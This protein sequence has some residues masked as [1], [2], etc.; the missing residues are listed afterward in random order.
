MITGPDGCTT[1][2]TT[3][4]SVLERPVVSFNTTATSGCM[5]LAVDF[6]NTSLHYDSCRWFFG[7][8][9][10]STADHPSHIYSY[11][12]VFDVTLQ[13]WNS[14][15]CSSSQTLHQLVR[16]SSTRASFNASH[17]MGCPPLDVDFIS[18]TQG[19]NLSYFW[20]FGD[21]STS[22]LPQPVHT[23]VSSGNF[24]VRLIVSDPY[25]CS[26][27]L[28]RTDYIQ[29]MNPSASY[30][31]PPT[32]VGCAPLTTRFTDA[33][34]GAVSWLWDFGDGT[35]STL[36]NPEH[37]YTLPGNYTVS[38]T[39]VSAGGGCVQH[40]A[41]FSSFDVRGGYAGFTHQVSDC[42]PYE[43]Q[44]NDT[45]LNA[46]S[47]LWNFGDGSISTDQ[48]PDHTFGVGGYHSV[49]LTITT[50]DG[51]SY[52]TMQNNGVYF[53]PF[54]ANFYGTTQDTAYP[55][56]V[57]FHANSL[58][59]TGWLWD[60]G[61]GTTSTLRDPLHV[62]NSPNANP[63]TLTIIN[64]PCSLTYIQPV[65]D[66]GD[67]DTTPVN[68]GAPGTPVVQYGCAP[69]R[70]SFTQDYQVAG[71]R[72]FTW[73]FGDGATSFEQFPAH[74]YR[75]PGV[76]SVFLE[77]IDSIG[78]P[79]HVFLDSIVRV[80]G[81]G[82][83][84]V[85]VQSTNCMQGLVTFTDTSRNAVSW[86]W[87][88]GDG[89]SS[90]QQHPV[91]LFADGASNH[92]VTQT[93]MDTAGCSSSISTSLFMSSQEPILVTE[94]D[95]CGHDTVEFFTSMRNY[96]SYVWHF[97]DGDSSNI[98]N[99]THVYLQEGVFTPSLTT[100]DA[101]GCTQTWYAPSITVNLPQAAFSSTGTRQG[102]DRLT[103]S[104]INLSV[105]ADAYEWDFGDGTTSTSPQPSH[106]YVSPGSYTVTL[107][108]YSDNCISRV[109]ETDYFRV[110]TAHAAFTGSCTS[111]CLPMQVQYHD[112]SSNAVS[113]NWTFSNG[114]TSTAANPAIS[115]S[116]YVY[117]PVRLVITDSNGCRDT[118]TAAPFAPHRADF[119]AD[120]RKGCAPHS[121]QFR[122]RSEIASNFLWD[123]GD[124][125]T[126][127]VANPSHTYTSPGTY[128]V[129][130]ISWTY[131]WFG[132]CSDTLRMQAFIEAVDPV[133]D[134][135]TTDLYACAPSLVRFRNLSAFADGYFWDFGDSTTS[136][137]DSA[138]HIYER[139]G[140]Y[141][142]KLVASSTSGCADSV[143]RS[144]YIHVMGPSTDF[145]VSGYE[146][147]APYRVDLTDLSLNASD[148]M[149]TFG[150]GSSSSVSQPSHVFEDTGSFRI[151]LVTYDTS[152]CS[153]FHEL[154]RDI[155]VHP[156]PLA[157]FDLDSLQG[158]LP[159]TLRPDN[160]SS[161]YT[162]LTWD[163]GDGDFS[164]DTLPEHIYGTPGLFPLTLVA[165][166]AHGCSDTAASV[167]PIEV[168]MNPVASFS[169]SDPSGCA[170]LMVHF[171]NES[172][173]AD[174]AGITW[175]FGNG[176]TSTDSVVSTV[177]GFPGTYDVS[178]TVTNANGCSSALT[179]QVS[180]S[181][182]DTVPPSESRINS[183]SVTSNTTVEIVWEVNAAPDLAAYVLYRLNNLS[184][185]YEVIHTEQ[186][187][188]NTG[189]TLN[190]SFTDT[191][192]N[193]LY[194]TYTYKLQAI[195]HCGYSVPLEQ[196]TPHTTVNISAQATG[197]QILVT[198]T[199][200]AG[201]PVGTY[202]VFRSMAGQSMEFIGYVDGNTFQFPDTSFGC[203]STYSYRVLATDLCGNVY[204]SFSDTA[205]AE[206][207]ISFAGQ[208]VEVV[209]STV[210][211]NSSVLTEW[212]TPTVL[213]E[214]VVHYDI[215]RSTDNSTFDYLTSVPAGQTEYLDLSVEVQHLN[216]Y[217]RV[218]PVNACNIT[219]SPGTPSSTIVLEGEMDENYKVRLQWT[220]YTGWE[221][222]VDYYV[223]EKQEEDGSW[224]RVRQV[225]GT[226]TTF[227]RQE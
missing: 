149:W 63:I 72:S 33:T 145:A 153:S 217:Y 214:K 132:G 79:V 43:A 188:S 225:D 135:A 113:W 138:S 181:F 203:P 101:G 180:I 224:T 161:G 150:D 89:I 103:A 12:G 95:V 6:T 97:G 122:N 182:Q 223:I 134:F 220:P 211:D 173:S 190:T 193:T 104:L 37:T 195:D 80:S 129:T 183:V 13:C 131:P 141:T 106:D 171:Q 24:D 207:P 10:Y 218:V 81:P 127:T 39:T 192:L 136:T 50:S 92:I 85:S 201:C 23:Y 4:V 64:H 18:S 119:T 34:F 102:C 219:E 78:R 187:I 155:I 44:F 154:A 83:G 133:A 91:H 87:S 94:T 213:P 65:M 216:Y 9:T 194:N 159:F 163:F 7:D 112:L 140:I 42:P 51:C 215:Y 130:L 202:E 151:A 200:Y 36:Q 2:V 98:P 137:N 99:P 157:E 69:L 90:T 177:Y 93:V 52:S 208:I 77:I 109:S 175:D 15:G 189:F 32:T 212:L 35:T 120:R 75:E 196:L 16:V 169:M 162:S 56:N 14:G 88:F 164:N 19:S 58:G 178:L 139:P 20:D 62:Y 198:W 191:G 209:R 165:I 107:T 55:L 170:P 128:D 59:A 158:C 166:N 184:N 40:I 31:P 205:S 210:V 227:E 116:H 226:T 114:D 110:D 144:Q 156:S 176:F 105:N 100:Y 73:D 54:G 146:G 108:V 57:Q 8:G 179:Q 17:R 26:D 148:W 71:A 46:V 142:V 118:A 38:L 25:G 160:L 22:N 66:F 206:P 11:S 53:H 29:T 41:N 61:D 167:H 221:Q 168:L 199:P 117:R 47:W 111:I 49:A 84:F 21:G 121:V 186:D 115:V 45:S 174:S 143:E 185:L 197:N 5:P 68:P 152:G 48:H 70:V 222:G 125:T 27:T 172:T 76:Y 74:I 123:F 126:S 124:G 3:T 147:C 60:F 1:G 204:S 82:A 28:S 67:P 30:I 96:P 86:Q